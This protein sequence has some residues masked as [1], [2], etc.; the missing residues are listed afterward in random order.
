MPVFDPLDR[1][2][3]TGRVDDGFREW[4]NI[5]HMSDAAERRK[6]MRLFANRE[7]P[8]DWSDEK[9][10]EHLIQVAIWTDYDGLSAED[11]SKILIEADEY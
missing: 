2:R 5:L 10:E 8:E 4:F 9:W 1:E 3:I 7:K 11:V 6:S